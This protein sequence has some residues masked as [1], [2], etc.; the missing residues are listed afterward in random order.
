MIFAKF[1]PFLHFIQTIS[2]F[3]TFSHFDLESKG[4]LIGYLKLLYSRRLYPNLVVVGQK[5][6]YFSSDNNQNRL[7][8]I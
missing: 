1:H 6:L 8:H 4:D 3:L 2:V 7:D 5:I